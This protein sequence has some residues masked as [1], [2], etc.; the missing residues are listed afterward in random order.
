MKIVTPITITNSQSASMPTPL[1]QIIQVPILFRNGVR[2]WSPIDGYLYAWFESIGS[3]GTA[4]IWVSIPSSI[5]ANGTYQLYMIQDSTL[6][7]DGVYWGEAPQLS[8][9][10]GQYDNGANVFNF[11]DNFAGT[12]LNTGKWS[13][14]SGLTYSVNNGLSVTGSSQCGTGI[15]S[16]A[17]F[18][19]PIIVEGYASFGS[20]T[21]TATGCYISGLGIWYTSGGQIAHGWAPDSVQKYA[22]NGW[23]GSASFWSS[24]DNPQPSTNTY[25]VWGL[26]YISASSAV[27][28]VNYQQTS[29][30][31]TSISTSGSLTVIINLQDNNVF[32]MSYYWYR[33]RAYPPNGVMPSVSFG[34]PQYSGELVTVTVP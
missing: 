19:A 27:G 12:S 14:T 31:S 24:A 7:M 18:S 26:G 10:Y 13:V 2:F 30:T 8:S 32:P 17:T 25:Y 16:T 34:S 9:T 3:N 5:P 29:S 4:T 20:N 23:T 1:Q 22:L 21:S 28:Y 33:V 11:Y 15:E 6:P